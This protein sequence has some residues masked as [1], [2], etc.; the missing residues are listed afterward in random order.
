MSFLFRNYDFAKDALDRGRSALE[1]DPESWRARFSIAFAY[2]IEG[3]DRDLELAVEQMTL[4]AVMF[5]KDSGLATANSEDFYNI[6]GKLGTWK[7]ELKQYESAMEVFH[8]ISEKYPDKNQTIFDI[9]TLLKAQEKVSKIMEYL[10]DLNTQI[11]EDG[12]SKLV[13]LYHSFSSSEHLTFHNFVLSSLKGTS[14]MTLVRETFQVAIEAANS[15]E[16]KKVTAM[17]LRYWYAHTLYHI[18]ESDHD[19]D[20]AL[21]IWEQNLAFHVSHSTIRFQR[22]ITIRRIAPA[23]LQRAKK[24]GPDTP[25]GQDLM[26]RLKGL[27]KTLDQHEMD[28]A[29]ISRLIG[30][31]CSLLGDSEEAK[32]NIRGNVRTAMELLSD[33]NPSN[34]WQG[35]IALAL[36]LMQL[37]DDK[38][39]LAA[40]SL[41]CPTLE[42]DADA[43]AKLSDKQD[44][45]LEEDHECT[46][47]AGRDDDANTPELTAEPAS[48]LTE[49]VTKA[50]G[51]ASKF[52]SSN[53]E[54]GR[55]ANSCDGRCSRTW[56]FP[57]DMYYC[58]DCIDC[59]FDTKCYLKLKDGSLENKANCETSHDFL[60]IPKWDAEAQ[61]K[62]PPNS[63]MVG[64][65]VLLVKDWLNGIWKEWG[66]KT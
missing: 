46:A 32:K 5:R 54:H 50:E 19:Y 59:Q 11:N 63:V 7:T 12:L 21:Q 43:T 26:N 53:H 3:P 65:N 23:Y 14:C 47:G 29:D 57:D 66:L 9:L 4:V 60:Y 64:E 31:C 35:Y 51:T 17:T 18:A 16:N 58:K 10:D 6:L 39:A 36:A 45:S 15:D 48:N 37:D 28:R 33:D 44:F 25:A 40:W 55:M 52:S 20:E 41:I 38:N 8:E 30:R 56:S 1:L 62:L 2:D 22:I 27:P 42:E 49:A 13:A 34:D 61:K 24:L